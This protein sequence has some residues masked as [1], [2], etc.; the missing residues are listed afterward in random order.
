MDG[1][2][3]TLVTCPGAHGKLRKIHFPAYILELILGFAVAGVAALGA[4]ANS[5]AHMLLKVSGYNTLRAEREAL[6]IHCR[7]L[8]GA[9]IE[10]NEKLASMQLLA[11]DVAL[12]YGFS[13]G[14][15]PHLPAEVLRV[16]SRAVTRADY[17]ASL[18]AFHMMEAMPLLVPYHPAVS[19]AAFDNAY[20]DSATPSIWPV[21]GQFTA[22]FGQR[23]DPF[24]GEAGFHTG[25]DI[26]APAGTP[27][28]AAGDG[29]LFY[30]GPEG[31][32]GN[33]ALI[34][35]GFG[36]TTKYAHLNT[37]KVVVGERVI[38]GQII[39]SVGMTGRATGPHLH[40]EVLVHGTPVNPQTY[41]GG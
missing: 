25:V 1:K 17:N 3:Y 15:R 10:A 29:L 9:V 11:A 5:Y 39:G 34:D 31:G 6:Q 28:R 14:R 8:Q 41:L 26:A 23:M 40:Y 19:P 21:R 7:N 18:W 30:A 2:Y 4:L 20:A 24:S 35:H 32:Y 12:A 37:L 16:A 22:A 38:R 13:D 36:I 27:V 33:E